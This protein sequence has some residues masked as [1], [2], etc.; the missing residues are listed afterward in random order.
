MLC[1]ATTARC[2]L[3]EPALS[4]YR[5]IH[6]QKCNA[7]ARA[8]FVLCSRFAY[9]QS[10]CGKSYSVVGDPPN[11]GIIPRAVQ[12][13]YEVVDGNTNPDVRYHDPCLNWI[14]AVVP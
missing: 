4:R 2:G 1:V 3:A 9:G 14:P 10:G 13:V 5:G 12:A 6:L 7:S 8:L 11:L